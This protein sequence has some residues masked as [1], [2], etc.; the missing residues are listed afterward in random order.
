MT[1]YPDPPSGQP[2]ADPT[3]ESF[4]VSTPASPAASSTPGALARWS[5]RRIAV[6]G[7][8]GLLV[9]F[10][11]GLATVLFL[12]LFGTMNVTGH[13]ALVY[14][15]SGLGYDDIHE[16]TSVTVRD[17]SG[18]TVAIGR[19]QRGDCSGGGCVYPFVVEDVPVGSKFYEVEVSH[20]GGVTFSRQDLDESG[21][22]LSLG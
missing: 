11:L 8:V 18:K 20:R 2:D 21:A 6:V 7:C 1:A 16:G 12:N 4:P 14:T 13:L 5:G 3:T 22:E 15:G 19:L 10:G 17:E 9:L